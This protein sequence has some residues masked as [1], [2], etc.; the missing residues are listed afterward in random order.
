MKVFEFI[1]SNLRFLLAGTLLMFTSSYGQTFFFSTFAAEIM[2]AF[3]LTD[4]EWG[5]VYTLATAASAITMFWAG[6]L[7]DRFAVRALSWVVLP[8]L[9]LGC[10]AMALNPWVAGLVGCVFLLRLLGQGMTYQLAAVAMARWFVARRGLALSISSL[11]FAVAT[12]ALPVLCAVLLEVMNWRAIWAL[13]GAVTILTFPVLLYLLA[14]ERTPQSFGGKSESTGM[15]ARHWTRRE[16]LNSSLFLMLIPLL[17][18]PPA[19]GTAL[20][21]QQVHIASVKGFSLVAYLSLI[22]ILTVV[23]VTI[24]LISGA[25]IDRFGTRRLM[26]VFLIPYALGFI[27]LA[28][29][30]T[31]F[32]AGVAFAIFGV[33]MGLQSTVITAFWAEYYGTRHIGAIK[34]TSTSIMVFGSAIGPGVTGL[35]IDA[36]FDFPDQMLAISVYFGIAIAA[37]W[38]AIDRAWR[39]LSIPAEVDV[40]RA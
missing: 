5:L 29:A 14:G 20:F 36:G 19:W 33:G 2:A 3:S 40:E 17:L 34:A 1:R 30:E 11:G 32:M 8:G 7:A 22:P 23:A 24:T 16:M 37:T 4:G 12:S 35:L 21:F 39:T 25:M 9:A 38:I 28:A 27:V 26:Q 10:F 13:A 18:G 6:A 15:H 31:L